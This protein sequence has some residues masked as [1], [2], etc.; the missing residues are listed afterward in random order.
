MT[1][2]PV[3]YQDILPR[4]NA[5][6]NFRDRG[7]DLK[8]ATIKARSNSLGGK[9]DT[10]LQPLSVQIAS[11]AGWLANYTEDWPRAS[12]VLDAL[13]R[14]LKIK[15]QGEIEQCPDGSWGP[16]YTEW[17]RKLESTFMELLKDKYRGPKPV[18]PKP[19]KLLF[20]KRLEAWSYVES[21]LDGLR[22]SDISRTGRNNRDEF[23]AV[24]TALSLFVYNA[25]LKKALKNYERELDFKLDNEWKLNYEQYLKD[26]QN[27]FTG[28][29]G[30]SYRFH[31]QSEVLEAQ[32]LTFTFHNVHYWGEAESRIPDLHFRIPRL[33]EIAETLL[34]DS[35]E[36]GQFPYGW[37]TAYGQT[38][39]TDWRRF[40]DHN[41]YDVL[42]PLKAAWP[43]LD[44][45]LKA[46]GTYKLQM[47]FDWCMREAV[48]RLLKED[49]SQESPY[50][51][52]TSTSFYYAVRFLDDAG[53]WN[54]KER[55][56]DVKLPKNPSPPDLACALLESLRKHVTE[57]SRERED[58]EKILAPY[59]PTRRKVAS[60]LSPRGRR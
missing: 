10:K 55:F 48:P 20:M 51:P 16:G 43:V 59:C 28:C 14:S 15:N 22:T 60:G 45:D 37:Q 26:L 36:N 38:D 29:W 52:L 53:Y 34:D 42:I 50:N 8:R 33:R 21:Y 23:G 46:R 39:K 56:W 27:K 32:D 19:K 18:T 40:S 2:G 44:T 31:G 13:E 4:I 35:V 7:Y 1:S 30:P 24:M 17:Y 11:E 6:W 57:D 9:V 3:R 47:L 58:V 41:N 54:Q 25:D 49:R 5:D 12:S